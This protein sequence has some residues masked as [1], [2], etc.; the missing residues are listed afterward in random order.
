MTPSVAGSIRRL[1]LG[2][3]VTS[4]DELSTPNC[5]RT[6]AETVTPVGRVSV[7]TSPLTETFWSAVP[8]WAR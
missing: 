6:D 8:A 2:P 4:T 5:D 7:L 3:F 1:M